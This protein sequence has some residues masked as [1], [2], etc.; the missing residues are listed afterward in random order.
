M[1]PTPPSPKRP[2]VDAEE[3]NLL[4]TAANLWGYM[5][6][7]CA[8]LGN[9]A[10]EQP[11]KGLLQ[12]RQ[13]GGAQRVAV[14]GALRVPVDQPGVKQHLDVLRHR[15]LRQRQ[16]LH[17]VRAAAIALLPLGQDAQYVEAYR[18]PQGP[19]H[20]REI[21]VLHHIHRSIVKLR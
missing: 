21:L 12:R 10:G 16:T 15:G 11:P 4:R 20:R 7:A 5:W 18:L 17:H 3:V 9:E 14:A 19:E 6:P 1:A 13:A 8:W 2:T